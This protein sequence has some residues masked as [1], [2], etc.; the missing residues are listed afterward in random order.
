MCHIKKV[1]GGR[2]G[3]RGG[4]VSGLPAKVLRSCFVLQ[5]VLKCHDN[6]SSERSF[7]FSSAVV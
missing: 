2:E 1:T 7:L 3:K 5:R 6:V 4:E